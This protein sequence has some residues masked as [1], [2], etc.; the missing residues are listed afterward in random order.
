MR[1]IEALKNCSMMPAGELLDGNASYRILAPIDVGILR[2]TAAA[3]KRKP[4]RLARQLFAVLASGSMPRR[5][6]PCRRHARKFVDS[7][8][9]SRNR[10]TR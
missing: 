2:A 9:G 4:T 5:P 10:A 1:K 8:C 6:Q 3:L 7:G